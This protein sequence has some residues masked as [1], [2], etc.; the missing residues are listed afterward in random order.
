MKRILCGIMAAAM[1]VACC[2]CSSGGKDYS[3][4]G[5]KAVLEAENVTA[6][7]GKTVEMEI[8]LNNNPGTSTVDVDLR[9]DTEVLTPVSFKAAGDLNGNG[10]FFSNLTD[11][12]EY[13]L[14][15]DDDG[16]YAHG[17]WFNVSDFTG[18][19]KVMT[20]TFEVSEDAAAGEYP[21]TFNEN[22]DDLVNEDLENVETVYL[23]GSVTVS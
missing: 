2:A 11:D 8:Y 16:T 22:E 4:Y 18:N 7:A 20:V 10:F 19:G 5:D 6:K 23:E 1:A 14:F 12:D 9:Y 3:E 17:M 13:G 21:V 15:S